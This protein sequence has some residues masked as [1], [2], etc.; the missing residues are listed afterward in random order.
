MEQRVCW[1][2]QLQH[3]EQK[4]RQR[5]APPSELL[6]AEI[7]ATVSHE[8]RSPLT[9][10]TGYTSTLL[11]HEQEITPEERQ[12]FL[13]AVQDAGDRI[14]AVVDRL[15]RISQLE[16]GSVTLHPAPLNL[17]SLVQEALLVAK[18]RLDKR[19]ATSISSPRFRFRLKNAL[20]EEEALIQADHT[21]LREALDQ[22]LANAIQ[23]SPAGGQVSVLLR[24]FHPTSPA[25]SPSTYAPLV[26]ICVTDQG[27]GIPQ[28]QLA[29]IFERFTRGDTS[30]TRETSGLGLGLTMCKYIARLHQGCIWAE[31][32]PGQGSTFHLVL[33]RGSTDT[34]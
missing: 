32:T 18:E 21:L 23:Y 15:L 28:E 31:S 34:R 16:T 24:P 29:T 14:K 11:Q 30:L 13:L 8:L 19:G 22:M 4:A 6:Q 5:I 12:A 10:I 27:M 33:P 25:G 7:L 17:V 2:E 26:E 3:R 9:A 1:Q 20:T